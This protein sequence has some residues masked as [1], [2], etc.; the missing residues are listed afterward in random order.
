MTA[1]TGSCTNNWK[2]VPMNYLF[3]LPIRTPVSFN[4]CFHFQPRSNS[5]LRALFTDPS[6]V[7]GVD[8]LESASMSYDSIPSTSENCIDDILTKQM[9]LSVQSGLEHTTVG[10]IQVKLDSATPDEVCELAGTIQADQTASVNYVDVFGTSFR[11]NNILVARTLDGKMVA[12][13]L[14]GQQLFICRQHPAITGYI[15]VHKELRGRGVGRDF[16]RKCS[17]LAEKHGFKAVV[18]EETSMSHFMRHQG[19]ISLHPKESEQ[20]YCK[21]IGDH[22]L[23][24]K[25]WLSPAFQIFHK[26]HSINLDDTCCDPNYLYMHH[27]VF[28]MKIIGSSLLFTNYAAQLSLLSGCLIHYHPPARSWRVGKIDESTYQ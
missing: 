7:Y 13:A 20:V 24:S 11:Q 14:W 3:L 18:A 4:A 17:E 1:V 6:S 27:I 19:F 15:F 10:G 21:F 8:M 28:S 16:L 25:L 26:L 5:A 9:I 22:Q 2:N 12:A 23:I